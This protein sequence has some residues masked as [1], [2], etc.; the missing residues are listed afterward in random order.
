[1]PSVETNRRENIMESVH[2][3]VVKVSSNARSEIVLRT[4]AGGTTIAQWI[5]ITEA[6]APHVDF[7]NVLALE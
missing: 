6:A 1:M 2:A 5:G 3:K 4:L 7:K